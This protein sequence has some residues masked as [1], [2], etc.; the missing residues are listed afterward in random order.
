[1]I[2]LDGDMYESTLDALVALY[3]KLSIGGYC[4]IDDYYSHIGAR[5]A[6]SEYRER[7]GIAEPIERIDWTGAFWRKER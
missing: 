1:V 7:N 5:R 6:V 4:I 3:P 2:H